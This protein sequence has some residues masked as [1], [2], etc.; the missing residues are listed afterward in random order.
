[1]MPAVFHPE[2]KAQEGGT[3]LKPGFQYEQAR[4]AGEERKALGEAATAAAKARADEAKQERLDRAD[5]SAKLRRELQEDAQ[6]HAKELKE[7][8]QT[9][10]LTPASEAVVINRLTTQWDKHKSGEREM[11]RQYQLMTTGLNRVEK[12]PIGGSQAVL[13]T[14]QKILDPT[15]VVR[16]TEYA[17]SA[18][19]LAILSRLEGLYDRYTKG[20]AGVPK[21]DLEAMVATAKE[22]LDNTKG[23]TAGLRARVG[24]TADHFGVPRDLIFE[25]DTSG[26]TDAAPSGGRTIGKYEV[27]Q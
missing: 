9:G 17:R 3:F 11:Q 24:R 16:E 6:A 1:M 27:V 7:M 10:G 26:G 19:G 5:D 25:E 18:S 8:S 22:F 4:A 21:K 15:S 13:V 14:F 12:D 20:G 23:S 2:V